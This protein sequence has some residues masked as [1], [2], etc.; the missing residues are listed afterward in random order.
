M[1]T[2]E[3]ID[4]Y[5]HEAMDKCWC[6]TFK[7]LGMYARGYLYECGK[8]HKELVVPIAY[9]RKADMIQAINPTYLTHNPAWTEMMEWASKQDW[10]IDFIKEGYCKNTPYAR[11]RQ[12]AWHNDYADKFILFNGILADLFAK[13]PALATAI[14]RYLEGRDGRR[15]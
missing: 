4:Q 11:I 12:I 6:S 13:P 7:F 3:E 8:C 14:T 2:P 15:T 5:I 1:K 9:P 10:W